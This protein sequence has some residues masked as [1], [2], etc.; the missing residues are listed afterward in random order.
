M[1]ELAADTGGATAIEYGLLAGLMS[2]AIIAAF[3][4]M[5]VSLNGFFNTAANALR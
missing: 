5:G 3:T 1:T 4:S 2:L